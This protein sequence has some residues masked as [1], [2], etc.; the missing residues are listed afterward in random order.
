MA[1]VY[2]LLGLL[3]VLLALLLLVLFVPVYARFVYDGE[4]RLTVRVLGIPVPLLPAEDTPADQAPPKKTAKPSKATEL[5]RSLSDSFRTDGVRAT[6]D[7]LIELARIAGT[8][9]GDVLSAIVVDKLH[10]DLMIATPDASDTAVRYGQVCSV[11]YPALTAISSKI[12]IRRR[13]WRVEPN[14]LRE[15]SAAYVDVRLHVWVYRVLGAGLKL[16]VHYWLLQPTEDI[17]EDMN[18]GK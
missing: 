3:G 15:T 12:K 7:Y 11:L 18:H 1:I 16:L 6:V 8:A 5:K 2:A 13:E 10:L 14:F 17:K 9:V 4:V